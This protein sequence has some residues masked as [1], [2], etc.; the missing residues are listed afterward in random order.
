MNVSVD[1]AVVTLASRR[2]Q[3]PSRVVV[4]IGAIFFFGVG[5]LLRL[6]SMNARVALRESTQ[7]L[8]RT[9]VKLESSG[10][11]AARSSQMQVVA[12]TVVQVQVLEMVR[13]IQFG[14][15]GF[16]KLHRGLTSGLEVSRGTGRLV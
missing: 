2:G 4:E 3:G 6:S 13:Y 16:F 14:V 8:E 10:L 15:G 11:F 12:L 7:E 1:L 5:H 9:L